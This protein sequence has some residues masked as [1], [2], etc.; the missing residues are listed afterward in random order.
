VL[1]LVSVAVGVFPVAGLLMVAG[2]I[3]I[4]VRSRVGRNPAPAFVV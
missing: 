4:A 3:A 1:G 2:G